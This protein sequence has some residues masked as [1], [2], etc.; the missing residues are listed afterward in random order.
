MFSVALLVSDVFLEWLLK[1]FYWSNLDLTLFAL[2][3]QAMKMVVLSSFI[4]HPFLTK[5]YC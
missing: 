4:T 5:L 1:F 3:G 2:G